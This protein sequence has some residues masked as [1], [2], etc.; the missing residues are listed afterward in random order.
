MG[1]YTHVWREVGRIRPCLQRDWKSAAS[2]SVVKTRTGSRGVTERKAE[3]MAGGD[4]VGVVVVGCERLGR[5]IGEG[6]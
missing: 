2:A 6:R 3:I 4:M 1:R 5:L